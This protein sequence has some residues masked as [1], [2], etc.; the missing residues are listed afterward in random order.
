MCVYMCST[1]IHTHTCPQN[2]PVFPV[3]PSSALLHQLRLQIKQFIFSLTPF[4]NS[5]KAFVG[6]ATACLSVSEEI[7]P[8]SL[9]E[10]QQSVKA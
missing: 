5:T 8:L 1:Y 9:T 4:D 7:P 10:A 6:A 3:L 2:Q